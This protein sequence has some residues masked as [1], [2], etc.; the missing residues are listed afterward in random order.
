MGTSHKRIYQVRNQNPSEEI[1][2]VFGEAVEI[3][4]EAIPAEIPDEAIST[5]PEKSEATTSEPL[6]DVANITALEFL[7]MGKQGYK[8]LCVWLENEYTIDGKTIQQWKTEFDTKVSEDLTPLEIN[9]V[10]DKVRK[11]YYTATFNLTVA[12]GAVETDENTYNVMRYKTMQRLTES[13]KDKLKT[14]R[15]SVDM[16]ERFAKL[17]CVKYLS[18][19]TNAKINHGFWQNVV[20]YLNNI[21]QM[22]EIASHSNTTAMKMEN[23]Y[24]GN[25]PN[26]L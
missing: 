15:L 12:A 24:S 25:L 9:Q 13:N 2:P 23:S 21:R 3:P 26:G 19:W 1:V 22:M 6:P 8:D 17:E 5:P 20:W 14:Q 11:L 7:K 18:E 16:I 4:Q 10:L